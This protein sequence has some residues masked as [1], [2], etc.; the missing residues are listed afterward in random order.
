MLPVEFGTLGTF[1]LAALAVVMT[2]SPDTVLISRHT[3]VSGRAAGLA[4]VAGVQ[5]GLLGHTILAI[6]GISVLT[7]ASPLAFKAVT[8]VGAFYLAWLGVSAI[9]DASALALNIEGT[10]TGLLTAGRQAALTNLL[11]PKVILL[12]LTLFPNFIVT[13]QDNK[14]TQ[15]LTLATTF[16]IINTIWQAPIALAANLIRRWLASDI[17]RRRISIA[18]AVIF[19]GFAIGLL[20]QH[21]I[22]EEKWLRN[23]E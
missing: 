9:K 3:L 8:I 23:N 11:N 5:V 21:L 7:A 13:G 14:T 2:P 16:T 10:Q 22:L 17:I 19:I 15:L 20:V 18:S 12:F 1:T 4:T 6:A